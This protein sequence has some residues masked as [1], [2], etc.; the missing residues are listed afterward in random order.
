MAQLKISINELTTSNFDKD[1]FDKFCQK[2]K[3]E[4]G[5]YASYLQ[6][7]EWSIIDEDISTINDYDPRF[8]EN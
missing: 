6:A 8:W 5:K 3:K 2:Y 1:L 7:N 4:L